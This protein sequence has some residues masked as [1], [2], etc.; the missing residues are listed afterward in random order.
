MRE[1]GRIAGTIAQRQSAIVHLRHASSNG[2]RILLSR[3][4]TF[5]YVQ[6]SRATVATKGNSIEA[7]M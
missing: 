7:N 3:L 6:F 4:P 1:R 5:A 2:Q